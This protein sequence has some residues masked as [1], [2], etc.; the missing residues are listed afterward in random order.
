MEGPEARAG[1]GGGFEGFEA[2]AASCAVGSGACAATVVAR[3]PSSQKLT[4]PSPS[5]PTPAPTAPVPAAAATTAT[6]RTGCAAAPPSVSA[7]ASASAASAPASGWHLP[8]GVS[9][10][11]G[12]GAGVA[13]VGGKTGVAWRKVD[14]A[15]PLPLSSGDGGDAVQNRP[16]VRDHQTERSGGRTG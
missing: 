6:A 7:S 12:A 11:A 8:H 16:K 1:G 3:G 4:P 10:V 9:V 2:E 14:D 15:E 13:V 5:P